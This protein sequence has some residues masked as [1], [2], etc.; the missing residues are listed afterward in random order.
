M[1]EDFGHVL[2]YGE[3]GGGKTTIATKICKYLNPTKIYIYT[4]VS[5]CY[6]H[7]FNNS[8]IFEDF[9][10][11]KDIKKYIIDTHE[12]NNF[13]ILFDDFN[14]KIN[15]QT[16]TEYIEL[17][18]KFRHYNTRIINLAHSVK[19]IGRS[20]RLNCRYIYIFS[21]I[22]NNET[23]KDLAVQYFDSNNKEL[24]KI[25][26][27]ARNENFYNVIYLD[28]RI[29]SYE[30]INAN[31]IKTT[32]FNVLANI[33]DNSTFLDKP[34]ECNYMGCKLNDSNTS[35]AS[36]LGVLN[37]QKKAEKDFI[38]NSNNKITY[39]NTI[40]SN[41]LIQ[42]KKDQY[43]VKIMSLHLEHKYSVEEKKERLKNNL[44][45]PNRSEIDIINIIKDLKYFAKVSID[46]DKTNY[47]DYGMLFLKKN[48]DIDIELYENKKNSVDTVLD[49]Y[50]SLQTSPLDLLSSYMKNF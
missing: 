37:F 34:D 45:N 30:I 20:V 4:G 14:D 48:Y 12:K 36:G 26:K 22:N 38:D 3:T 11:I 47:L 31:D 23:I 7:K 5:K 2:I 42:S 35:N 33:P 27:Q 21:T 50:Q 39:N 32:T 29:G 25:L 6:K 46:V 28:R 17:F 43:E 49:V 41:Q 8:E 15:T 9:D 16:N 10:N 19:A 44:L 24:E 1:L 40:S 13:I 18:T